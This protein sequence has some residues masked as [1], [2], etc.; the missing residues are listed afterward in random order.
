MSDNVKT[1]PAPP[2]TDTPITAKS[3]SQLRAEVRDFKDFKNGHNG[4][5]NGV[6]N[7]IVA[8]MEASVAPAQPGPLAEARADITTVD[9]DLVYILQQPRAHDSK[10]EKRFHGWLITKLNKLGVKPTLM[11][12]DAIFVRVGDVVDS[13]TLFC[14]HIDTVHQHS[15]D[16]PQALVYDN[17]FGH[18][19]LDTVPSK[20]GKGTDPTWKSAKTGGCLGADDGAGVWILLQMIK[21]RVK[22]GYLFCRG[23]ERGFI[24]SRAMRYKKKEWFAQWKAAVAFDRPKD[25]EVIT[26][27]AR[28]ECASKEYADELAR[29]LNLGSDGRLNMESSDQGGLT[30][31]SQFRELV[32]ECLNIAVGY[33]SHHSSDE[34]VDYRHLTALRDAC[35]KVEWE[36]LPI[37]RDH[38]KVPVYHGGGYSG[39]YDSRSYGGGA[40]NYPKSGAGAGAG[41]GAGKTTSK[42]QAPAPA[43][44]PESVPGKGGG[45]MVEQLY[46]AAKSY[47]DIIDWFDMDP[48]LTARSV[49]QALIEARMA[50]L[51]Y[52][53]LLSKT[54]KRKD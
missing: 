45:S 16:V 41:A 6:R 49:M 24:S 31:T 35:L 4:V 22:G 46:S 11:E 34:Y 38:T 8:A 42:A 54:L 7:E 15:E 12:E 33:F 9:E 48:D 21:A 50:Q 29:Q 53:M 2:A 27:Q 26:H 40:W 1:L 43:P 14:C 32:P 3:P 37:A 44:V 47:E 5:G 13:H 28:Q 17:D 51:Q 20:S 25:F 23:E 18:I 10:S 36:K 30:D 19:Y 52:N 39:G